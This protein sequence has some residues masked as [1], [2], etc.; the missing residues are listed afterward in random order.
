M[1]SGIFNLWPKK[2][3]IGSGSVKTLGD[4]IKALEKKRVIVFTDETMKKFEMV[5]GLVR[6]LEEKGL[7][8]TLF[9]DIGP[10]PTDTMV[11][12][13]V[14]RMKED[15]PDLIVCIGGGSSIDAAKAANVVYTHGGTIGSYDIAIGGIERIGPKLLPFIAIPT[16]A[17]TGSEVTWVSVITDTKKHLKYGVLSPLLVPDI[18]LLDAELTISLPPST[19]AFTGIDVLTHAIEAYVSVV[20]F[21]VADGLAV[22]SIKMVNRSLITAVRDGKNIKAREDMIEAS[23]MAGMAFNVNGLGLCHQMA[24]Q[25]SAYFDLPHGLANAMLLP[26]VMKFNMEANLQKF[27]DVAEALGAD[28]RGMSLEAA[29][30]KSVEL[31]ELLSKKAG[32]PRYLDDVSVTKDK[33]PAMVETALAD[34]V[35]MNNPKR[36]TPKECERIYLESFKPS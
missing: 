32:I 12:N 6:M 3:I 18:S 31:V 27:A 16:T 7:K 13:A 4:E 35:G 23:M 19:T 29:A 25:L 24:H 9:G 26:G 5:T 34:P 20:G 21:A 33:V 1:S 22:Q 11:D 14:A 10:N 2:L 30:K 17:G 8:V 15:T 36:T 28:I